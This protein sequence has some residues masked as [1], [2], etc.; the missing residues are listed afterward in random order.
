MEVKQ[1][2]SD[3]TLISTRMDYQYNDRFKKIE[4]SVESAQNRMYRM[5]TNWHENSERILGAGR[6][7]WNSVLLSG[8]NIVVELLKLILFVSAV[9]VKARRKRQ[10][11]ASCNRHF[12]QVVLDTLKPFTKTRRVRAIKT[13]SC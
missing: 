6:N 5:E 3:L 9:S 2:K 13:I 11:R 10:L 8:L 4:E 12:L 1:L 7:M